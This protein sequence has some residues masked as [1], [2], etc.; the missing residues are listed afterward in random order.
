[1]RAAWEAAGADVEVRIF[2]QGDLN[3]NVIRPRKYDALLFGEIIGRDLDLF[4]FWHSSQ[5]ND[6]GLNIALYA[7]TTADDLLE[8]L[9]VATN[10]AERRDLYMKLRDEF[11]SDVPA[12]FLYAPDFTYAFPDRIEGLELTAISQPSER[13][14]NVYAWHREVDRVWTFLSQFAR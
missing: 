3:Q 14:L 2:E 11:V 6:P 12:V 10:Q 4:A 7:N 5:R 8:K 1:V 13:Y 9:R